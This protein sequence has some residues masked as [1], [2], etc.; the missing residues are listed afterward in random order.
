MGRPTKLNAETQKRFIDGLRLGLTYKL[1]ASYAGLDISTFHLWMQKGKAEE[2]GIYSDFFDAIKAAEGMC[3]AQ[4]MGRITKAA[5]AGQWQSSAWVMERRFGYSS[6]QEVK[7]G[8]SE[9]GLEGAE[10]LIAKVAEIAQAL[11]GGSDGED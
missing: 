2:S 10:D 4:H 9:D 3:A 7:V 1:A 6:R 11:K 8:A 5:E